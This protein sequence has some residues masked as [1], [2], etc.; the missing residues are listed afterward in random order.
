MGEP[1]AGITAVI[2]LSG[3]VVSE[4]LE[5]S[6]PGIF[7]CGN[8]LHVHDLV[9]FVSSESFTAGKAA[10]AYVRSQLNQSG[11]VIEVRDGAGVRGTVPQKIHRDTAEPVNLM[12]RPAEVFRNSSVVI[13]S[14]S[15]V[16]LK[17]KA[18]IYTPGEMVSVPLPPEKV[19]ALPESSIT[20]SIE[21]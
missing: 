8:V 18:M 14:G 1:S 10:A 12:F 3:A 2:V 20:V 17:K 4:N 15:D 5:T 16:I 13:R 19:A 21:S 11:E 9:D 6:V 7:A